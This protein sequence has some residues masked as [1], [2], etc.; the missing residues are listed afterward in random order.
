MAVLVLLLIDIDMLPG[1][2]AGWILSISDC[3]RELVPLRDSRVST[4]ES[5]PNIMAMTPTS[6]ATPNPRRTRIRL[7]PRDFFRNP[8]TLLARQQR[9]R[10][11]KWPLPR[12]TRT[13]TRW[14]ARSGRKWRLQSESGRES[15]PRTAHPQQAGGD[16]LANED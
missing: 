8:N 14:Y 6:T 15:A 10:Q 9:D 13:A 7:A 5:H 3:S 16:S 4:V 1:A 2:A 11:A 12:H